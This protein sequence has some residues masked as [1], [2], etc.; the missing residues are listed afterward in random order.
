MRGAR[1]AFLTPFLRA[2]TSEFHNHGISKADFV[3]FIDGLNEAFLGSPV[4]QGTNLVGTVLSQFYGLHTVQL[5]GGIVQLASGVGSAAVSYGRTRM[6]VQAMNENL[7][8]PAGL[9]VNVLSTEKMLEH[10]GFPEADFSSTEQNPEMLS[11]V[12]SGDSGLESDS[13]GSNGPDSATIRRMQVLDGYCAPLD[14]N[15]PPITQPENLL[16]RMGNAQAA[17]LTRKHERKT[18]EEYAKATEEDQKSMGKMGKES[19]K[20][21]RETDGKQRKAS[22]KVA[23]VEERMAGEQSKLERKLMSSKAIRD[24]KEADKIR[25]DH[26]KEMKHLQ[27]DLQKEQ[28]DLEKEMAKLSK[29]RAK[30]DREL[31]KSELGKLKAKE[32]KSAKKMRWIVVSRREEAEDESED[33]LPEEQ[34]V[35]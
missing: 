31:G 26:E 5:A 11:N 15:V 8:H 19:C 22:R 6:Y 7:F 17:R 3:A 33:S 25:K 14:Y 30:N 12:P 1:N 2:Y 9:H 21:D 35:R 27:K 24:P 28:K 10:V 29:D 20:L 32:N 16:S 23:K 13:S 4:F 18:Q 34:E